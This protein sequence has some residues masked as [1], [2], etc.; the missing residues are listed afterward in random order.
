M[1]L[2][3]R[4]PG[5][6]SGHRLNDTRPRLY[7][8]RLMDRH[9]TQRELAATLG[10]SQQYLCDMLAGRRWLTASVLK[11]LGFTIRYVRVKRK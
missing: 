1:K 9:R 8:R 6:Y 3:L 10:M 11:R 4:T 5:L 2:A 7:L